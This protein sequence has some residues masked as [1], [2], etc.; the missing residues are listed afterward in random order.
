MSTPE[1]IKQ[2]RLHV[3]LDTLSK[4][5]LE[6]AAS[7]TRKSL[8]EFVL[9]NALSSAEEVIREHE[10]LTLSQSDWT[11]FMDAL[12]NPPKPNKKLRQAFKSHK[13]RIKT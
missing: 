8:S 2:E 3:R 10:T 7:Y 9:T 1:T 12:E 11:V 4:Q 5:K 13:Q 6:R